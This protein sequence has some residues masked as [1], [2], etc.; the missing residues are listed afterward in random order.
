MFLREGMNLESTKKDSTLLQKRPTQGDWGGGLQGS[1]LIL[2][3]L[4]ADVIAKQTVS[5]IRS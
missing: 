3:I 1:L 5:F 4:R 2:V